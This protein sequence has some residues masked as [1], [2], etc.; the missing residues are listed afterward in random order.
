MKALLAEREG[1]GSSPAQGGGGAATSDGVNVAGYPALPTTATGDLIAF[2][3]K[4]GGG[5][6]A[7]VGRPRLAKGAQWPL[8]KDEVRTTK[9]PAG[10]P[11]MHALEATPAPSLTPVPAGQIDAAMKALLAERSGW[12]TAPS[13]VAEAKPRSAEAANC[14]VALRKAAAAGVIRFRTGSAQIDAASNATLSNLAKVAQGCS[15]GRIRVEGHT[16]SV[17]RAEFNKRLSESRAKAVADFLVTAG[18][19]KGRVEAVGYGP[20]NPVA[21][22]DT[23]DGRARNRRIEFTVTD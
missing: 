13:K 16:D 20:D 9:G 12:G 21:S 1:W 18:V 4:W 22:N 8:P 17:G 5:T 14:E 2:R 23:A 10:E 19:A 7:D 11:I 15:K 6:P 3:E